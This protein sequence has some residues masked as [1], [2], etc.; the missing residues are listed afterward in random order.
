MRRIDGQQV[1][2]TGRGIEGLTLRQVCNVA[3]SLV[4]DEMTLTFRAQVAAGAKFEVDDPL[5]ERIERFEE[6][7]GLR[8]DPAA[9]ALAMH[10]AWMTAQGKAWDDTPVTADARWWDQDVE[11]TSMDDLNKSMTRKA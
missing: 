9:A 5:G 7:I 3:Y 8:F 4:I 2:A 1:R 11:F 10:K 6:E